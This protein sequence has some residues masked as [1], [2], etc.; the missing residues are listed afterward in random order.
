MD[1]VRTS[2]KGRMRLNS[3]YVKNKVLPLQVGFQVCTNETIILI[4]ALCL[5]T[6]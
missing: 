4:N 2:Y 5:L 1:A 3:P 6:I